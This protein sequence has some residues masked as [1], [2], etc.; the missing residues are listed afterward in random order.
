M[1]SLFVTDLMPATWLYRNIHFLMDL[2]HF[3]TWDLASP[4]TLAI[5]N[6]KYINFSSLSNQKWFC[7]FLPFF[8]IQSP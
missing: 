2:H 3:S 8:E 7:S 6:A 5:S 1:F 4:F